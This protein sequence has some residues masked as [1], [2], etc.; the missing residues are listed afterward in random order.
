MK[1]LNDP[2]S[3]LI[4]E[5]LKSAREK[6]ASDIHFEP[7]EDQYQIRFRI[8]GDLCVWKTL[9]KEITEIVI[10][11][12]KVIFNLDLGISGKPQD[13]RATFKEYR[14]DVRYSSMPTIYGDK[15]VLRILRQDRV[16]DLKSSDISARDTDVLL[17]SL[18][19]KEGLVIISGPTGSGK[20]T[21][22]YGL[23]SAIDGLKKNVSTLENPV[24][25]RLPGITQTDVGEKG[26][27]FAQGLRA[28]M[29]QDPD[30]ILVGEIRDEETAELC[31]K[32]ASTGHLVLSTIHANSALEVV[33]RL[34]KLGVER[35]LVES[36]LKLSVA[37]RLVQILCPICATNSGNFDDTKMR[38]PHG[39]EDCHEGISG[40]K[41]I[42][43][44][45]TQKELVF[46]KPP[47]I[48]LEHQI[49]ELTQ[50]GELHFENDKS[51]G[52]NA[53]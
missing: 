20:T 18:K 25:Y 14:Y 22:L 37:Q 2:V 29:R 6:N 10:Q 27:S 46:K 34:E 42:V 36:C 15:I 9:P 52:A 7:R 48:T 5:A 4:N 21:T 41:P 23:V 17:S 3:L 38:N 44:Y 35:Y 45:V 1:N 39:C 43:E 28:L 16:F 40:R 47:L 49:H 30:V 13:G 11:K 8:L 53:A 31:F 24:E 33:Q 50:K 12:C 19:H 32:A 26:M 51:I